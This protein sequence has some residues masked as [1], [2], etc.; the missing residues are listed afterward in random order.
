[1]KRLMLLSMAVML[2]VAMAGC[3]HMTRRQQQALSGGAIGAGSGAALGAI[4]GG[5]PAL[6]AGIGG[7]AGAAAGYLWDDITGN[8][9]HRHYRHR[10][11]R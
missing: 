2:V 6:G 5:N 4:T 10:H 11:H 1:M 8:G 3:A 7:A 9:P